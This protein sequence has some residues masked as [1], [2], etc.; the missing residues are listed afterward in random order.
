MENIDFDKV[1]EARKILGL[2]E[3]ATLREIKN[4]YRK[5]AKK[6]HPDSSPGSKEECE[7][8]MKKVNDAY[9]TLIN[10]CKNYV[11]SFKKEDVEGG[12]DAYAKY[13]KSFENDWLWGKGANKK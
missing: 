4:A 3:K 9:E 1:E 6:Y 12:E 11:Y 13:M 10:Y 2:E 8:V 5:K 7:E